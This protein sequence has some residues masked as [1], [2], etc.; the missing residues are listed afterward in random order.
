M[1]HRRFIFTISLLCC[2][3][4]PGV[5]AALQPQD[6]IEERQRPDNRRLERLPEPMY[7]TATALGL[8][9][10]KRQE[11]IIHLS[12]PSIASQAATGAE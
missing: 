8:V 7:S 2:L 12:T 10:R 3:F 1:L 5:V 4:E 6:P 11:V 9:Q